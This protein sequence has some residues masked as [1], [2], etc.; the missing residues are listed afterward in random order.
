MIIK[1]LQVEF[2]SAG[3]G[4]GPSPLGYSVTISVISS[5]VVVVI[6]SVVVVVLVVEVGSMIFGASIASSLKFCFRKILEKR[7]LLDVLPRSTVSTSFWLF[8]GSSGSSSGRG[9]SGG[10]CWC[11][12][13]WHSRH[14]VLN[15]ST[16][17][18]GLLTDVQDDSVRALVSELLT[19]VVFILALSN[20]SDW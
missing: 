7:I 3:I 15:R 10:C 6:G 12:S 4:T 13:W 16:G 19:I 11:H 1:S 17:S 9:S 5:G 14:S 20:S 8:C 18:A 2:S